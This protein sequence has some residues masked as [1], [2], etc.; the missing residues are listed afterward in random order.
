ML[1]RVLE[2]TS[3]YI[4][5]TNLRWLRVRV[6]V[7]RL[8]HVPYTVASPACKLK[9]LLIALICACLQMLVQIVLMV[10]DGRVH[11]LLHG[12]RSS[13]LVRHLMK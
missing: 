5:L 10:Q 2:A 8:E 3:S 7:G 12:A 13:Y 4:C 6:V 9:V 1:I 11:D